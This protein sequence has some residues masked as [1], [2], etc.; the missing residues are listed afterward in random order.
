MKNIRRILILWIVLAA[1]IILSHPAQAQSG[2]GYDLTWNT[3]E[4]GRLVA[5]T[6]GGYSLYGSFGQPDASAILTGEGYALVGG[7][8]SGIPP[9]RLLLPAILR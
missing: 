6:G 2:D 3:L 4:S 8:W 7:F 1:V 5:A 9:Y